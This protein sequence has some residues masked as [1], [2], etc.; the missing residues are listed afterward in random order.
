LVCGVLACRHGHGILE[1]AATPS[2]PHA[3]VTLL[4]VVIAAMSIKASV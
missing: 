2:E 3:P 4:F 1:R